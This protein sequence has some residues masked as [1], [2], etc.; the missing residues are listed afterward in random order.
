MAIVSEARKA[1]LVWVF[2]GQ[3]GIRA[4]WSILIFVA[5]LVP[6]AILMALL[7]HFLFHVDRPPVG[8]AA[9]AVVILTELGMLV[10]LLAATSVMGWIEGRSPW[11][12]GLRGRRSLLIFALGCLGGLASLSLLVTA[13]NLSGYLLFAGV[14]LH[15]SAIATYA[16]LWF[17][18]FL[19]AGLAEEWTMRGYLLSTLARGLGFWPA[20]VL[21][22]LLFALA[23][24]QNQGE[25]PLGIASVFAAG[26]AF[27]ALLRVSGSLWLGI[28]MHAAWDWAQSYL[29]GTPD[30]AFMA[31]GH[32]LIS[33]AAGDPRLSGG[34]VGPEGSLLATPIMILGL[35]ALIAALRQT[36]LVAKTSSAA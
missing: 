34:A 18:A 23:H 15:G 9:P 32:L 31:K 3:N 8:E 16:V 27:C 36:G 5:A 22:S 30:S 24:L 20:A 26:L 35:L 19:L 2:K 17:L 14:A 4:G 21:S 28:G 11:S 25:T 10:P 13:L 6:T 29:Y 33:H 7:A 1:K 12:Y